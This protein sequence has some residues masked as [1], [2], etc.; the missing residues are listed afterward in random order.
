MANKKKEGI[1][2]NNDILDKLAILNNE[3]LGIVF[4]AVILFNKDGTL[5]NFTDDAL[6]NM[7]FELVKS[8]IDE[9]KQRY[10]ERCEK[11][12]QN[13]LHRWAKGNDTIVYDCI[14]TN[15]IVYDCIND[16]KNDDANSF[17][18]N[19]S[20]YIDNNINN[21]NKN[22]IPSSFN[23]NNNNTKRKVKNTS[24]MNIESNSNIGVFL[25]E[26]SNSTDL[27][28]NLST[29]LPL[30]DAASLSLADTPL[31][32]NKDKSAT[33]SKPVKFKKEPY[34]KELFD[35]TWVIYPHKTGK[36]QAKKTFTKKLIDYKT[37]EEI[38]DKAL[39]IY[40]LLQNHITTWA[41]ETDGKGNI[42]GRPKQFIPHFS[43]WL[44]QNVPDK[45]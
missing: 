40:K 30:V 4:K 13:I 7:S 33:D 19:S 38:R 9:N 24:S 42:I 3:Q 11:N 5:P 45:E 10:A 6:L 12:K 35:K 34:I 27:Q 43:T 28:D 36:E 29:S 20:V 1:F 18:N 41:K 23:Q 2:V 44:N 26:K 17:N 39:R 37:Q 16:A 31:D 22:N 32:E 25:K 8:S 15:T 21:T 14:R